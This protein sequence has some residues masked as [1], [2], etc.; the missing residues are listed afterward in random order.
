GAATLGVLVLP[1]VS[2]AWR[3]AVGDDRSVDP[4]ALGLAVA[5]ALAIA[6][7]AAVWR[8]PVPTPDWAHDWLRLETAAGRL[9]VV[10]TI[11]TAALLARFDDRVVDRGVVGLAR[12]GFGLATRLARFDD[13]GLDVA[14]TG[15]ARRTFDLAGRSARIDDGVVDAAVVGFARSLRRAGR[16]AQRPQTGQLHEYYLQSVAV[17]AGALLLLVLIG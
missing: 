6:V 17:L 5:A 12:G 2:V 8:W 13:R 14:V 15:L 1:P 3:A 11:R 7:L 10:P 9:V 4:G 16:A